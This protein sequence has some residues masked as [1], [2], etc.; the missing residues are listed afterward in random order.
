MIGWEDNTEVGRDILNE[1]SMSMVTG[2]NWLRIRYNGGHETVNESM[3][4]AV[5][6]K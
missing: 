2:F 5:P 3:K 6:Q 4:L 1:Q